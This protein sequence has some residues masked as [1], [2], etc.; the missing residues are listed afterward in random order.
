MDLVADRWQKTGGEVVAPRSASPEQLGRV[1]DANHLMRMRE[2]A[3][4]SVAFDPDTYTSPE[5]YEVARLAAGAG[6]DAVE[7]VLEGT[8]H[9]RALVLARPP[10]HHAEREQAMGFCFYN[11]TA[12]AAAHARSLGTERVAVVDFDVHHGNGTQQIFESDPTVLYVSVHQFPFYPGTG[13]ADEVGVADGRGFT[14]NVPLQVGAGNADYEVVFREIVLPVL[15]AFKPGLLIVSAGFDAH[16]RDPLAGMRL[17]TEAFAAMTGDLR[18]VAEACCGGRIV[19]LTEGG[20][21]LK[22][23]MESLQA[24]VD[25]L[26][27]D[28]PAPVEWPV[29]SSDPSSKGRAAV[30]RVRVAQHGYWPL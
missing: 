27:P 28:V 24:V 22:A 10:G 1:H 11:N 17:T 5:T 26:S 21:D 23:L 12:V 3:G 20:Y 4:A 29:A 25:V 18:G 14:V 9:G 19:M 30:E 15:R 6:I 7:R 2:A 8:R 16:E 13:E